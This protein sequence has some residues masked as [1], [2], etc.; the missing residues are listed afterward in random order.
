MASNTSDREQD[1]LWS[2]SIM[3][4]LQ[5]EAIS[6]I[7]FF[8]VTSSKHAVLSLTFMQSMRFEEAKTRF[9]RRTVFTVTHGGAVKICPAAQYFLHP[10]LKL[11]QVPARIPSFV[12]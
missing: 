1:P 3:L 6:D 8:W 2:Y 11:F 5:D 12:S 4:S 7:C 9:W 10:L